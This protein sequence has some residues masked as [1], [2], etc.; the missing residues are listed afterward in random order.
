MSELQN[1]H[2]R[3]SQHKRQER[4]LRSVIVYLHTIG[5]TNIK[6]R[7]LMEQRLFVYFLVT[8]SMIAIRRKRQIANHLKKE[9][10]YIRT[11]RV[12]LSGR[13]YIS[14]IFYAFSLNSNHLISLSSN[15]SDNIA[16]SFHNF[17][18]S[19]NEISGF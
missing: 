9:D 16:N 10:G 13:P 5:T 19:S 14:S 1:H 17:L 2:E 7:V 12:L 15:S 18:I 8:K 3:L 11:P 4:I 6:Q